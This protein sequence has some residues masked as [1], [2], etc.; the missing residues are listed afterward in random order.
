MRLMK[1]LRNV[2]LA[3]VAASVAVCVSAVVLLFASLWLEHSLA[4]ELPTPTGPYAVGRV[5]TT[6][7]DMARLDQF[8]PTSAQNRMLNVWLWYPAQHR[9]GTK[10]AAYLSGSQQQALA[11]NPFAQWSP[12]QSTILDGEFGQK[13]DKIFDLGAH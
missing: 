13:P 4:L 10:T 5:S 6:W 7:V 11:Q 12:D 2:L 1:K 8:A 3:F 9:E